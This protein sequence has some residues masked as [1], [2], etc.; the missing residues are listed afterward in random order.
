MQRKIF[1]YETRTSNSSSTALELLGMLMPKF[2][3]DRITSFSTYGLSIAA[4]AGNSTI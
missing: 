2:V 1:I 4:E 3:I